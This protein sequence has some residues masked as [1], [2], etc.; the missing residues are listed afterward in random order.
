M[1]IVWLRHV[2]TERQMC[3]ET[4]IANSSRTSKAAAAQ[5]EAAAQAAEEAAPAAE[6]AAPAAKEV[7]P[8]PKKQQQR[9]RRH[10]SYLKYPLC[11]SLVMIR[12]LYT[13]SFISPV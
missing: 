4:S 12:S 11:T 7:A 5:P 9:A 8:E 3:S 10:S 6:E 13:M 1:R 2:D